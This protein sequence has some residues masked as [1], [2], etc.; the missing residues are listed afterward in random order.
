MKYS[1][2]ILGHGFKEGKQD[3][4]FWRISIVECQDRDSALNA[5]IEETITEI[6]STHG[7]QKALHVEAIAIREMPG[8]SSSTQSLGLL[9]WPYSQQEQ[10]DGFRSMVFDMTSKNGGFEML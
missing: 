5:A 9:F 4:A 7:P 6:D 3:Y 1:V 2:T 10:L 8:A